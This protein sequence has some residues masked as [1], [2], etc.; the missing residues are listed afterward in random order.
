MSCFVFP[1][2][3]IF[4]SV[5][6]TV[7]RRS[8]HLV[9]VRPT[10]RSGCRRHMKAAGLHLVRT[11]A[12][13]RWRRWQGAVIP[14]TGNARSLSASTR[15]LKR[16]SGR[17]HVLI[18][19][20]SRVQGLIDIAGHEK[21]RAF[22]GKARKS[23][24][25]FTL[26]IGTHATCCGVWA[27]RHQGCPQCFHRRHHFIERL[28]HCRGLFRCGRRVDGTQSIDRARPANCTTWLRNAAQPD[29]AAISFGLPNDAALKCG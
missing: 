19:F 8:L 7:Q 11:S 20:E 29:L 10:R 17:R 23:R 27:S 15:L 3:D 28:G 9:G 2:G 14:A 16:H 22:A 4:G 1:P 13:R 5:L 12:S 26:P 25:F 18:G 6:G 24:A 21:E